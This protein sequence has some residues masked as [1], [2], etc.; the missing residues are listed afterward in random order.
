MLYRT[1]LKVH[2][3][4]VMSRHENVPLQILLSLPL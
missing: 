3:T 2:T 4:L 1:V